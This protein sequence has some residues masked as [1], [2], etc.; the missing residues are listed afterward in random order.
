MFGPFEKINDANRYSAE[1]NTKDALTSNAWFKKS[2]ASAGDKKMITS[3]GLKAYN[4]NITCENYGC[5]AQWKGK[6]AIL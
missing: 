5:Y 1:G 4:N 6:A 2:M 3:T